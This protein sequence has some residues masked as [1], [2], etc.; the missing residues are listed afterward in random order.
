[1]GLSASGCLKIIGPKTASHLKNDQT[2]SAGKAWPSTGR[3]VVEITIVLI[4]TGNCIKLGL[5]T[6][7]F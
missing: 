1:M 5:V 6:N 2:T 4:G 3:L 7:F